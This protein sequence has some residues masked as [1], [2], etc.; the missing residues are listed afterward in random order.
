[1]LVGCSSQNGGKGINANIKNNLKASSGQLK[2]NIQLANK[3]NNLLNDA[4]VKIGRVVPYLSG[5]N[6]KNIQRSLEDVSHTQQ[7]VKTILNNCNILYKEINSNYKNSLFLSSELKKEKDI[8]SKLKVESKSLLNKLLS[9][10]IIL[11]VVSGGMA[12]S[13]AFLGNRYGMAIGAGST[14]ILALSSYIQ[15]Y[16]SLLSIVGSALLG[17]T[18]VLLIFEA[19]KSYKFKI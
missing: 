16:S 3:S 7:Y 10:A 11:A 18:L 5:E 15:T 19:W 2:S 12:A 14:A 6:K 9:W 17:I 4:S 1:M 8:N 13:L